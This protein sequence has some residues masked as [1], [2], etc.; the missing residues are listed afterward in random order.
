MQKWFFILLM[1]VSNPMLAQVSDIYVHDQKLYQEALALYNNKQYQAS[2]TLFEKVKSTSNDQEVEANC[3]YYAANAAIRLNQMGADKRMEAFVE[4]Y[5]TSTKRNTA[6]K[7]VADYYFAIGK[8]AHSLKWYKKVSERSLTGGQLETFHF[9]KAYALF[10]TKKYNQS[11]KYFERISD[12]KKY[13]SQ[14]KY[15]LG[16]MAYQKDD[17]DA[18]NE[19]FDQIADQKIGN[20]KL[21]YY[22]ADMN[23]K[24]G[25]FKQ[26]IALAKPQL[27][28]SDR[29]ETSELHKII[30]ESYF[31]LKQYDQ[32]I[33]HLSKYRGR[34]G[35]WNNTD[36]YLLGY[37]YYQ[38][39][40]Y[41]K[42]VTSFNKIVGGQNRVTQ[43]AYYHLAECYLKLDKK[44]EALHAFRNASQMD[45]SKAIKE[46]AA[47]NYARLSYEVGN[48]YESVPQVL[49]NYLKAYPNSQYKQEIQELLVDSYL[50]SKNYE[51]ALELLEKNSSYSSKTTYQKVAFYRAVE[52]Y[53]ESDYPAAL[54]YFEKSAKEG[55][56]PIYTARST[57]WKAETEYASGNFDEA[58]LDYKQFATNPLAKQCPEYDNWNYHIGYAYFQRKQY[59]SAAPYFEAYTKQSSAET[60]R[61]HDSY[62]RMGDAL[63]VSGKYWPAMEAYNKV[64]AQKGSFRD[65]AYYQKALS[66]GFVNRNNKKI[67]ALESFSKK[68]PRSRLADDAL[69]ELGNSYV[70]ANKEDRALQTYDRLIEK[71]RMSSF[72]PKAMLRQ[73][74]VHYNAGNNDAALRKFKTV[75]SKYPKSSEA[76]QAVSSAKLIYVDTGRVDEYANWVKN[77]DFVEVSDSELDNASFEAAE[78]NYLQEKTLAAKKGFRS[79]LKTYPNGAHA[80]K[81]N[82]YLAEI[83]FAAK[84][85]QQAIP[86]YETIIRQSNNNFTEQALVRLAEIHQNNFLAAKPILVRLEKEAQHQQNVTFAQ[87]NLMKGY[88]E[89]KNYANT[90]AYADK[91][92]ANP[93]IDDRIR[94][95]AWIMIARSAMQTNN[96]TKAKN[97]YSKVE[98]IA[99]GALVAEALYFR[100]YFENKAG[101]HEA[102]NSSLQKLVKD[103][104]AHKEFSAKGLVIMAKNFDALGDAFQATYI[105]ESVISN[106]GEY[107]NI[108]AEAQSEMKRIKA[109]E[110]K[111]NASVNPN[112]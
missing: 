75:V 66:Y 64:I 22:K 77:L 69:Y 106:F 43:N 30:G 42:A 85:N 34:K 97:A 27:Q 105:L 108:V 88:F 86:L 111:T 107:S 61:K 98:K 18:A 78:K 24:L 47:L 76:I 26:A 57:Y 93:N 62:L 82:F 71:Y 5:P 70:K 40:D 72:T 56:D 51:A 60:A 102:S 20:D 37:S 23:F 38:Q 36:H 32:A 4:R 109:K 53:N 3:A 104:G 58:I 68:F 103:Y 74:L 96:H 33:P 84:E 12:S 45:F 79:Y 110:A 35:K 15:Y 10:S 50:T 94:S 89:S 7:D 13:G 25:K 99:S 28:Q 90:L 81:A 21:P 54:T 29:N 17:Y 95:D 65:Y 1:A 6:F 14:A 92:L 46:D 9:N 41:S 83:Y 101:K 59:E 49:T 112:D 55:K 100:A 52:L 91:V 16:Y 11:S 63:F 73:G 31:N 80:L 44:S 87:S 67:E 19:K 39:G 8:Y 2:Q 48:A